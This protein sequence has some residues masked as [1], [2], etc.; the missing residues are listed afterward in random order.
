MLLSMPLPHFCTELHHCMHAFIGNSLFDLP[1]CDCP[2]W[3]QEY[4]EPVL[5]L[6]DPDDS[7]FSHR[8]FRDSCRRLPDGQFIKD[9]SML[10]RDLRSTIIVDNTPS[11]Y[12]W[13]LDNAVPISSWYCD[14]NDKSL[15][16][17]LPLLCHLANVG[18]VRSHLR[19]F[20][21]LPDLVF[22]ACCTPGRGNDA[23]W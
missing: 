11:V 19:R 7:I 14:P 6:L 22:P 2:N 4:A 17:L 10:G 9:L 20:Y 1:S 21:R 13:N 12:S 15:L 5:D 16:Q 18:D 23:V 3:L 8:L